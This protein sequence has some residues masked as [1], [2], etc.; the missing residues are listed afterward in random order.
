M[1][2]CHRNVTTWCEHSADHKAVRGWLFFDLPLVHFIAHSVVEDKSGDIF[3]ITPAQKVF[4]SYP[5]IRAEEDEDTF[6]SLVEHGITNID[7]R[8]CNKHRQ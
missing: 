6:E 1:H 8:L 3:D 2:E 7:L 5:F 4:Q